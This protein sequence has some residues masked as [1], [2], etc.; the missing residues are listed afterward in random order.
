MWA[1]SV[2]LVLSQ[3]VVGCGIEGEEDG[4]GT[5][6]PIIPVPEVDGDPAWS[7]DGD[8][9]AFFHLGLTWVDYDTGRY[10]EDL[11]SLGVWL[12]EPDGTGKRMLLKGADTPAWSPDASCLAVVRE[13]QIWKLTLDGGDLAQLTSRGN[14][15]RPVWSPD[16][17]WIASNTHFCEDGHPCGIWLTDSEGSE[18]TWISEG[19]C[20][21]WNSDGLSLLI[22]GSIGDE[23]GILTYDLASGSAE[24]IY[25]LGESLVSS[26]PKYSPDDS[27][28]AVG[29]ERRIWVMNADG[30]GATRI[31]STESLGAISWS[32]D[33]EHIVHGA[34]KGLWIINAD[35]TN[36]HQITF[37][38]N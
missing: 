12:V 24:M 23:R 21:D 4:N 27:R 18:S 7:P 9:I 31:T 34:H 11:D 30:T 22:V 17:K 29:L 3:C 13:G 26:G 37:P 35:G 15:S 36:P 10:D 6:P 25:P 14:N 38:P 28:I 19:S 20:S 2:I 32:P 33:G 8:L 16:G 5:H 1:V